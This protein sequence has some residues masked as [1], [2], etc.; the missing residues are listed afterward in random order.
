M[1]STYLEKLEQI[2]KDKD[3]LAAFNS[4]CSTV[5]KAGPGSGKTTVLT[6]KIMKLLN[7]KIKYPRGLACLTYNREAV[8]EFTNRLYE[9][10]YV[11]RSNVF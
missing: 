10:G 8:K 11:K 3:Q 6:L 1:N 9:L 4:N 5:V 7:E 2:K